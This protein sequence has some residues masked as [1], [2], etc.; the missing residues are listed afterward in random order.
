[1]PGAKAA[2]NVILKAAEEAVLKQDPS[3]AEVRYNQALKTAE[4]AFGRNSPQAGVVLMHMWKF[5]SEQKRW[6]EADLTRER[7]LKT[8]TMLCS[9]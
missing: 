2:V 3:L 5:Y 8:L 1:M 6:G 4:A 7:I 9:E